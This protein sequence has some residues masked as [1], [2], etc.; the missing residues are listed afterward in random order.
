MSTKWFERG[1]EDD[2]A[3]YVSLGE[4]AGDVN[5]AALLGSYIAPETMSEDGFSIRCLPMR[6]ARHYFSA[7]EA[8]AGARI[9]AA[10]RGENAKTP[11]VMI[12]LDKLAELVREA[13]REGRESVPSLLDALEPSEDLPPAAQIHRKSGRFTFKRRFLQ[14][15][16]A[17]AE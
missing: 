12:P 13:E 9:F 4:L 2:A 3:G 1:A 6:E 17:V 5:F 11:L 16:R 7:K 14:K 15:D 8:V 10:A